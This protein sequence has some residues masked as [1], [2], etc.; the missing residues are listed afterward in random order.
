MMYIQFSAIIAFCFAALLACMVITIP[1]DAALAMPVWPVV[2]FISPAFPL[3]IVRSA[4][5]NECYCSTFFTAKFCL[6]DF[7]RLNVKRFF[8]CFAIFSDACAW[9]M[10]VA[11]GLARFFCFV[12][13]TAKIFVSYCCL[14]VFFSHILTNK[15]CSWKHSFVIFSCHAMHVQV[16]IPYSLH[17]L[18]ANKTCYG[19]GC[20]L[21]KKS[22][23][24]RGILW[25]TFHCLN[26]FLRFEPRLRLLSATRGQNVVYKPKYI[27]FCVALQCFMR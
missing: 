8:A 4:F 16:Q 21:V 22:E 1:C 13:G 19:A 25:Y 11:I 9:S 20:R 24:N 5:G 10:I 2:V 27:I 26:L 12:C 15:G 7:I 18:S 17:L 6:L 14:T 23:L 3:R